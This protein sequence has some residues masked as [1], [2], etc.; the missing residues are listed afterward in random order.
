MA[1]VY[2]ILEVTEITCGNGRVLSQCPA[3]WLMGVHTALYSQFYFRKTPKMIFNILLDILIL[4][5]NYLWVKYGQ[6]DFSNYKLWGDFGVGFKKYET[7]QGNDCLIFYPCSK[8]EKCVPVSPYKNVEKYIQGNNLIGMVPGQKGAIIHRVITQLSPNAPLD[9]VFSSGAKKLIPQVHVHGLMACA[10]EHTAVPM[11]MA[12]HGY[13][14][15][16]PDML[17]ETAPWTTDKNGNDIWYQN[18]VLK[19]MKKAVP[20][21]IMADQRK[22]YEIRVPNVQAIGNEIKDKNFLNNL[23]LGEG[24]PCLDTERLFVSGQSMGG[25]TSVLSSSGD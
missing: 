11:Q 16:V 10:A 13:L 15:I 3:W 25:W 7:K 4:I 5:N 24:S 17:D 2:I 1:V 19:D 6:E 12:S 9:S 18:D 20:E 14:V 8:S 21:D 22:R 23:G